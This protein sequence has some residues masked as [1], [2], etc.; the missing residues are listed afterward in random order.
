MS[1]G[2]T[3]DSCSAGDHITFN[4][5]GTYTNVSSPDTESGTYSVSGD[6]ITLTRTLKNGAVINPAQVQTASI[7]FTGTNV[8]TV[9][10]QNVSALGQFFVFTKV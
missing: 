10:P 6:T 7:F 9:Y 3:I 2:T 8:V 4:S 1:G 5:D